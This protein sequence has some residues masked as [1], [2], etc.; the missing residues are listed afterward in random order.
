VRDEYTS[1]PL[2]DLPGDRLAER[3]DHL[4]AELAPQPARRLLPPRVVV[5]LAAGL[6][7]VV[8]ATATA[9]GTVRNLLSSPRVN[10]KIAYIHNP[11]ANLGRRDPR[12]ARGELWVMNADGSG[13]TRLSRIAYLPSGDDSP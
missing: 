5:V 2:R 7:I 9:F 11:S 8:V 3:K 6:V 4:V 12:G 1:P 10:S 13:R